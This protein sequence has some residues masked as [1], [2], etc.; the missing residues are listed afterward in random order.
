MLFAAFLLICSSLIVGLAIAGFKK[1]KIEPSSNYNFIERAIGD[2]NGEMKESLLNET[3]KE[4]FNLEIN[5]KAIK[6]PEIY[7]IILIDII[8]GGTNIFGYIKNDYK[9]LIIEKVKKPIEEILQSRLRNNLRS[10]DYNSYQ[11]ILDLVDKL[12]E[13]LDFINGVFSQFDEFINFE[14]ENS[15]GILNKDY[16]FI[17]QTI[18]EVRQYENNFD[19]E[20]LKKFKD[21]EGL[22]NRRIEIANEYIKIRILANDAKNGR[23]QLSDP[24]NLDMFSKGYLFLQSILNNNIESNNSSYSNGDIEK[25]QDTFN[26]LENFRAK[27]TNDFFVSES[28]LDNRFTQIKTLLVDASDNVEDDNYN[29]GIKNAA[30]TYFDIYQKTKELSGLTFWYDST[31]VLNE[32]WNSQKVVN[33]FMNHKIIGGVIELGEI[34]IFLN[35]TQT[36]IKVLELYTKMVKAG[37]SNIGDGGAGGGDVIIGGGNGSV[38]IYE[39]KGNYN[40]YYILGAIAFCLIVGIGGYKIRESIKFNKEFKEKE[41][42]LKKEELKT[43]EKVSK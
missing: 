12:F 18:N 33:K 16:S 3:E 17:K 24:N 5:E 34:E 14:N 21:F 29:A 26:D 2:I 8:G 22:I 19:R 35:Q 4:N 41:E 39:A 1:Q 23:L 28:W 13:R 25:I 30:T 7:Y 9:E 38:G 6:S 15:S 43:A 20:Q 40:L 27:V 10:D 31:T 42:R 37:S 32:L 11:S 36:G